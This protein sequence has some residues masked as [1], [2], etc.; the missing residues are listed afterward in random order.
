MAGNF[1]EYTKLNEGAKQI[2]I[3]YVPTEETL[4]HMYDQDLEVIMNWKVQKIKQ[5]ST[6]KESDDQASRRLQDN[7]LI[8]VKEFEIKLDF[9]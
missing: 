9:T 7:E 8:E 4:T 2:Y 5:K 6:Q 1:S 3:E